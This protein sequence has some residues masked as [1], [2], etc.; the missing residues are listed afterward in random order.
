MTCGEEGEERHSKIFHFVSDIGF[1]F[2]LN[3]FPC[4]LITVTEV[5][6]S[7]PRIGQS[8]PGDVQNQLR[9]IAKNAPMKYTLFY[10]QRFFSTHPQC[11]LTFSW[12]KLKMLF[13]CCLIHIHIIIILRHF[14]YLLYL[15]PCL[16]L[17]LFMSYLCDLFFD[18]HLHFNY[19]YTFFFHKQPGS[20]VTH[21]HSLFYHRAIRRW[22][23][24]S[25]R[26][27]LS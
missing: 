18:F 6:L 11:S 19:D 5:A 27:S 17:S 2:P 4:A 22:I 9:S 21:T 3:H 23:S 15:S 24:L 14:S 13:R 10:K 25:W 20:G 26:R 8:F 12:I 1:Q 7:V 16:E